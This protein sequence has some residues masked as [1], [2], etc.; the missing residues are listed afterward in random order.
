[1][2]TLRNKVVLVT[3]AGGAIAGSVESAF[4]KQG[5][6]LVLVDRERLRIEGRAA[7]Y[8]ISPI[9]ADFGTLERAQAVVAHVEAEMGRIDGL[10]HLVGEVV[11]GSLTEAKAS[12]F[13]R[14]FASNVGTLFNAVTAVLPALRKQDEAFIMGIACQGAWEGAAAG[15]GLFAAAKSAV[16]TYLR[17][18]DADL[19]DS[20]VQV[21]VVFPLGPVDTLTNR[22]RF[23]VAE[24]ETLIDPYAIAQAFVAAATLGNGGRFIELPVSRPR[25]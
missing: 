15:A 4:R 11:T 14:A 24:P 21:S 6:R 7:N 13:E 10:I 3:G 16:A 1:M 23:R 2:K 9:E 19:R 12:D 20:P 25:L 8:D 17:S 5:A 18:L 22:S